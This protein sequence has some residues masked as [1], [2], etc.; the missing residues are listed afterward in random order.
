V[1]TSARR[2]ASAAAFAALILI[3]GAFAGGARTSDGAAPGAFAPGDQRDPALSFDGTNYLVAWD[4]T[5]QRADLMDVV[6]TR[7]APSGTVLDAGG[8]GISRAP[9]IQGAPSTVFGAGEHLVV[10]TDFRNGSNAAYGA[11]VTP[12]GTVLDSNGI[13]I[14]DQAGFAHVVPRGVAFDGTRFFVPWWWARID[15]PWDEAVEGT[16][17]APDGAVGPVVPISH[18]ATG[19]YRRTP[20]VAFGQTKYLVAWYDRRAGEDDV[21]GARITPSGGVLEPGG[22]P[23]STA[24]SVQASPAIQFGAGQFFAVWQDWRSGDARIY[25]ARVTED[26][27]VLDPGG[28]PIATTGYPYQSPPAVG[29]DGTNYLVAWTHGS[30]ADIYCA[31]IASD[32]TVLDPNGI[33]VS[34]ATGDQQNVAVGFDGTNYL[35]VWQDQR[36]GGWDIYGSRVTPAGVVLDPNGILLSNAG[37]NPPPPPPP[38]P[39]SSPPPPPPPSPPPVPP[40]PPP[41]LPPPPGVRCLVPRVVGLKLGLAQRKIRKA[42]CSVG[43]VRRKRAPRSQVGVVLAQKPRARAIRKRG[44][45]VSLLVG[46]R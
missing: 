23:V 41:P 8:F 5:Q 25:G 12:A 33:P 14:Q 42:H 6:G 36:D 20:A 38:P 13:L 28:L 27:A 35:L 21:Y 10:W 45:A 22:V 19:D 17:I 18:G 1:Q 29:F 16:F 40:P 44:F 2:G 31:R 3:V 4:D 9:A 32:G 30:G 7:V 37:P 34:T 15:P 43:G 11:R 24:P 26:G 46:K 39:P